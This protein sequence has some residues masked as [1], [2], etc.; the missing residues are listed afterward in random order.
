MST[1]TPSPPRLLR[2]EHWHGASPSRLMVH[3]ALNEVDE[4]VAV[5]WCE[6]VTDDEYNATP[7]T[8]QA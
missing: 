8:S 5:H 3:L 6:H 4:H 2:E 1:S 7:D